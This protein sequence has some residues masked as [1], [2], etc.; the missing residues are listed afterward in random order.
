MGWTLCVAPPLPPLCS[1]NG[2]SLRCQLIPFSSSRL[3]QS[4]AL[5]WKAAEP[6]AGPALCKLHSGL[7]SQPRGLV[8]TIK[9]KPCCSFLGHDPQ[10]KKS[11]AMACLETGCFCLKLL[12]QLMERERR[13]GAMFWKTS[14]KTA[15]KSGWAKQCLEIR[16]PTSG[17]FLGS[18]PKWAPHKVI[19][20]I[21]FLCYGTSGKWAL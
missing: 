6:T 8:R 2:A 12:T 15:R 4:G 21:I 17:D 18:S 19:F 11:K 3:L 13:K 9:N 1:A 7:A 10:D 16:S 20:H 5:V 14:A